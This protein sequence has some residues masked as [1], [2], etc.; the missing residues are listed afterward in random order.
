[1]EGNPTTTSEH[2]MD[3]IEYDRPDDTKGS[4]AVVFLGLAVIV[5]GVFYFGYFA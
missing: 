2:P 1:M 3:K 4:R 5:I